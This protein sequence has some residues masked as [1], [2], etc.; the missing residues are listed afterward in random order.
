MIWKDR[1]RSLGLEQAGPAVLTS[2]RQRCDEQAW[3]GH[4]S[5]RHGLWALEPWQ[6]DRG[7][8]WMFRLSRSQVATAGPTFPYTVKWRGIPLTDSFAQG[9][10]RLC[11][12]AAT[13]PFAGSS[14]PAPL[15]GCPSVRGGPGSAALRWAQRD[16]PDAGPPHRRPGRT[17]LLPASGPLLPASHGQRA[18]DDVGFL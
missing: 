2:G 14:W 16:P 18:P 3:R 1:K 5:V 17:T 13:W 12:Q 9:S 6:Q 11:A 7:C 15:H 4:V 10:P 8:V